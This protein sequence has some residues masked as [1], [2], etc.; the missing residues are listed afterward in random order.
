MTKAAVSLIQT[1]LR[2]LGYQPG[3]I[4]GLYGART[5]AAAEG[6]I[7][8]GGAA[9]SVMLPPSLSGMI[10]Q[11]KA[12]YPVT[13]IVA[14]CSATRP[15]WMQDASTSDQ[16]AEIRRWH[17]QDRGWRDIGYHWIISRSGDLLAGRAET[18]I[19]AGVV[20]H[21]RGVIH[22]CLIGGAGSAETDRFRDNFTAAQDNTLRGQL[23]AIAMRTRIHRISGHNEWAA[24]A[25]PG[26]NV[27]A[28]LKEAA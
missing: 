7:K 10:F 16:V 5:R 27:P 1:G 12:R 11:G 15:G 9:V 14:H 19:G 8:A 17:M 6:W 25:C 3:P 20:G 21:N 4:D 24:K 23:Q 28:W 26:F 2:D 18:E 22:V 13:E